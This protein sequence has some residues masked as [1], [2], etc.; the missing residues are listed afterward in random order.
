MNQCRQSHLDKTLIKFLE[1]SKLLLRFLSD[2]QTVSTAGYSKINVTDSGE[3]IK[4]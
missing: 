4:F 3:Q 2:E 1:K